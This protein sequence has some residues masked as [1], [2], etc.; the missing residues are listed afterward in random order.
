MSI[1]AYVERDSPQAAATLITALL[2]AIAS[3]ASFASRAPAPRDP[4][5]RTLG[6]RYLAHRPYLIFF[7]LH[8]AEVRVHRVL[9][10]KRAY[11]HLL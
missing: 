4:R 1:R 11:Q 7:R 9:H 6:F 10:G 5:L 3:L 2:D 8:R